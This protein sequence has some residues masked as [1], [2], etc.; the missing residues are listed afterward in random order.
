MR[1]C[2]RARLLGVAERDEDGAGIS[3]ETLAEAQKLWGLRLTERERELVAEAWPA[4]LDRVLKR[5]GVELPPRIGRAAVF[6]PRLP[7]T[8]VDAVERPRVFSEPSAALPATDEAIIEC[9]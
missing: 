5:R 8:R 3:A 4:Q 9:T 7:Q 2:A 1:R 6:D